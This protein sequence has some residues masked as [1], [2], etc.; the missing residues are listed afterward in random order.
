MYSTSRRLLSLCRAR[1]KEHA[2]KRQV[3]SV[4]PLLVVIALSLGLQGCQSDGGGSDGDDGANLQSTMSEL[5]DRHCQALIKKDVETL[6]RLWMDDLTFVNPRGQLLTKQNRLDN[7][8]TGATA[9]KSIDISE[10]RHRAIGRDTSVSVTR[11]KLEGQYSGQEGSGDY[12]VTFVWSRPQ[13]QW[14][15]AALQMTRLE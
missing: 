12:R 14:Q 1:G 3:S 6:Q 7:V 5:V 11:C 10:E 9:F 4:I 13:D 15:L 8:R 2:M